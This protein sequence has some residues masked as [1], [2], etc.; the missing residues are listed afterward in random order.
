MDEVV[1]RRAFF[2]N[3]ATNVSAGALILPVM[4]K[5]SNQTAPPCKLGMGTTSYM[6]VWRPQDTFEFL[7]HC[8]SLGAAGIQS[9]IHGDPIRLRARAEQLGMYI[10][11]LVP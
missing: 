10:E 8:H 4:A 6:T 5:Q 2:R 3:V 7:E 9:A 11:D 1:N